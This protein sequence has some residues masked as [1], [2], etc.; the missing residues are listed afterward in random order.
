MIKQ[1]AESLIGR[2]LTAADGIAPDIITTTETR[3][4]SSLPAALKAFYLLAGNISM[5]TSSFQ[6]FEAP[7]EI[8]IEK[9]LLIFMEENQAVCY[10][11]VK[12]EEATNE[13]AIVYQRQVFDDHVDDYSED[14]ALPDFI[15]EILYYQCAQG[16]YEFAG[17]I[18]TDELESVE[19]F[20]DDVAEDYA[21]VVKRDALVIYQKGTNLIWYLTDREGNI[22]DETIYLSS[23]TEKE[24][25]AE[26]DVYGFEDL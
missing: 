8:A 12:P 13:E 18:V 19:D 24:F 17:S 6:R 22:Y 15:R 16:G 4:Q 26:A 25:E 7:A 1:I 10:W 5:L 23:L 21:L 3:L 20:L 2:A 11:G 9:G 14:I